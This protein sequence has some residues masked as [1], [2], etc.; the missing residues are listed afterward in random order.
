MVEIVDGDKKLKHSLK[1]YD[2]LI[3]KAKN[4][5]DMALMHF[6][7]LIGLNPELFTHLTK[8]KI[9]IDLTK[10]YDHRGL[11]AFYDGI[12]EDDPSLDNTIHLLPEYLDDILSCRNKDE[13]F[14][15]LV[16]TIIHETI[17]AN[18]NIIIHNKPVYPQYVMASFSTYEKYCEEYSDYI[19][20]SVGDY[21]VLKIKEKDNE[22]IIYSY[23]K[24]FKDFFVFSLKKDKIDCHIDSISQMEELLRKKITKF[25]VIKTVENPHEL[26]LATIVSDYSTTYSNGYKLSK[27]NLLN[28]DGEIEKQRGFEESITEAFARIIYYLK[29]KDKFEFKE[30]MNIKDNPNYIVL[31]YTLINNLDMDTIRWF[32]LSCYMEEYRNKF[33]ELYGEDYY[34]L[35]DVINN[36]FDNPINNNVFRSHNKDIEY[37]RKLKKSNN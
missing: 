20:E 14:M 13:M 36:A 27:K 7:S 30:L 15:D 19:H 3:N 24:I 6:F 25:R 10:F 37:I 35:I 11:I 4:V 31:A 29:D 23:H 21:C 5:S 12:N 26:N 32:F 1:E 16:G 2:R 22:Y 17:H 28:S 34:Q 33:Y 8:I 18:R 9:V